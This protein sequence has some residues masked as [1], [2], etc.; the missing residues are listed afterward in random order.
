MK[1]FYEEIGVNDIHYRHNRTLLEELNKMSI[2]GS[3]PI[4]SI[5]AS[6]GMMEYVERHKLLD[7]NEIT[8]SDHWACMIDI[9]FE[10]YFGEQ[11]SK[12]NEINK[13]ILNPS[14]RSHRKKYKEYLEE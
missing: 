14:K 7:H 2:K 1:Q 10:E 13:V 11:L 9:N 4:N 8:C 12:S 6:K 3:N 5:V